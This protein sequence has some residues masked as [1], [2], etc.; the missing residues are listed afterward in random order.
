MARV[1]SE[2]SASKLIHFLVDGSSG[3]RLHCAND[4]RSQDCINCRM[5]ISPT[6]DVEY[7]NSNG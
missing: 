3:C 7:R 6:L 1:M 4:D 5:T 2:L